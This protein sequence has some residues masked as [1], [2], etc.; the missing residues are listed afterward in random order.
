MSALITKSDQNIIAANNLIKASLF[1]PSIHCA[2]YGCVQLMLHLLRTHFGKTELQ[3]THEGKTGSKNEN[4]FHN[5][6][7]NLIY[8]EFIRLNGTDAAKFNSK[9]RTL[10][11]ARARAD[12]STSDVNDNDALKAYN[13]SC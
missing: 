5:W 9:I 13:I 1:S 8:I 12:Y 6:L 7:Q 2:Y 4:G 3:I 11:T 10:S